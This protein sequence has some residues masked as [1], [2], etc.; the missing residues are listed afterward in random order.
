MDISMP[1]GGYQLTKGT[2][3]VGLLEDALG[4]GHCEPFP[5][6][7]IAPLQVVN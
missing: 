6:P 7:K 1:Y 4:R 5:W 3:A 2:G